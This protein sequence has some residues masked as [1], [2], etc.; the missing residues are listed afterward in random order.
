[1][2]VEAHSQL[3]IAAIFSENHLLDTLSVDFTNVIPAIEGLDVVH[4]YQCTKCPLL[5]GKL[6]SVQKHFR[7]V[8]FAD[9]MPSEWKTLPAQRADQAQSSTWFQVIPPM[10]SSHTVSNS[11]LVVS[12]IEHQLKVCSSMD[13]LE[14]LDV[15]NVTPW[16]RITRWHEYTKGYNMGDLRNMVMQPN[17]I[18]F[19]RLK[20]ALAEFWMSS[21]NLINSSPLLLLQKLNTPFVEQTT[22]NSIL[23]SGLSNTP[24]HLHQDHAAR[25]E[26]Y[27][28]P[29]VGLL[30][31]LLRG[32]F[33]YPLTLPHVIHQAVDQLDAELQ[34]QEAKRLSS[35]VFA[36]L[37][38]LWT[39]KWLPTA[40]S[41]IT[42]PTI[43]YL[44]LSSIQK[45]GKFMEP[46]LITNIIAR[47]E[48]VMR[49][50]FLQAMHS[51][52][53]LE[54]AAETL[55]IWYQEKHDSTFNSLRSLQHI[56]SSIAFSTLS[57]PK[58]WWIDRDHHQSLLYKG[59]PIHFSAFPSMFT[60][61]EDR[62]AK[63]WQDD[64]LCGLSLKVEYDRLY[65]D[66]GN[67]DPGYSFLS[68]TRNL[69]FKDRMQLLRAFLDTPALRKRFVL[70][71]HGGVL[72]WNIFELRKWLASY[73]S[74]QLLQLLL[75]MMATGSPSRTTE[76]TALLLKNTATNPLRNLVVFDRH[77]TVLCTYQKTSSLS[78]ND[79]CI[80]HA[81]T[82]FGAD[83]LVQD[84]AIARPFAEVAALV[85]YPVSLNV[86]R[87]L[88]THVFVNQNRLFNTEDV[89]TALEEISLKGIGVK[90]GVNGWRHVSTA[91]R[92]KL[93]TR[94][95]DLF[96]ED[97]MDT[98]QA[99]QSGHSRQTENRVYALSAD[100][101]LG[102]P[103]DLLPLFLDASK[104][105]QLACKLVPGG[106]G[107]SY[108][109]SRAAFFQK[110]AQTG[111]IQ[112]VNPST[113]A[114]SD[115]FNLLQ[116]VRTE[117]KVFADIKQ[118][119]QGFRAPQ[120]DTMREGIA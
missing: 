102:A 77:V 45:D 50:A 1:M 100:S 71:D 63:I 90:L 41:P 106:L 7:E 30:G 4:V 8:H 115:L 83:L 81:L 33:V 114:S 119:L 84:L 49:L 26:T 68:D 59:Y 51:Q 42:D 105:W 54:H 21:S 113:T 91:F 52:S 65:D 25:M 88:K 6:N 39:Y 37:I 110:L 86:L 82:G 120:L 67:T 60:I 93:C 18:Q 111:I 3:E 107:L 53:D 103:E 17:R 85:S 66:I 36:V 78:G 61:I 108:M 87:L 117:M 58:I 48:Y 101:L 89:T 98:V 62:M 27:I 95:D 75:V 2:K 73:A 15:R 44:M 70:H 118:I 64:I 34:I 116:E 9:N 23:F 43:I 99:L 31:M 80:P 40:A 56:A 28:L 57:L 35:S 20:N 24:F 10:D 22:I 19:A 13:N 109:D 55:S 38:A 92:R 76:I 5:Y 74:F 14:D 96:E 29:V 97:Q 47:F 46:K 11:A 69:C 32:S 72:R 112:L 12:Q 104:D 16:L 94:L 79:K